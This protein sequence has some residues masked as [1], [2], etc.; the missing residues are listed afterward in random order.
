LF[1]YQNGVWDNASPQEASQ[2]IAV[3]LDPS[4]PGTVI[5]ALGGSAFNQPIFLSRDW[6]ET[7]R[8][9]TTKNGRISLRSL[10]PWLN[11]RHF[12][13]A[14]ADL[15]VDPHRPGRLWLADWMGVWIANNYAAKRMTWRS[16]ET[17]REEMVAMS[18]MTPPIGAPLF[19]G[20]VDTN[21]FRHS[22]VDQY[23]LRQLSDVGIW[24]SFG[25]D[26]HERNPALM[27][28]V[29]TRGPHDETAGGTGGFSTD[30][31]RTWKAFS[32][33]GPPPMK[34]AY[35]AE[36]PKRLVA[37]GLGGTPQWSAD[38]GQTWRK[39]EGVEATPIE[40]YWHWDHPLAADRVD[41]EAFYLHAADQFWV[42]R[43][44]GKSFDPKGF[45]QSGG[46][47][48]VEA[49][50]GAPGTAWV[51][52][53]HRGLH[54]TRDY[55]ETFATVRQI[56]RSLLFSLGVPEPGSAEPTLFVYG[57]LQ[58]QSRL[59]LYRS[60]DGGR[61]WID[62]GDPAQPVGNEPTV[63]RGDRQV[64][65]RVFVGTNGRGVFVGTPR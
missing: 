31:G 26:F 8:E 47:V 60:T 49:E 51:S 1:R 43:N 61:N 39:A 56:D 58:G 13:G 28:R 11:S 21:G 18:L 27:V 9:Y 52:L 20:T 29:G 23:P 45:M 3:T 34:I 50:P 53:D 36:D 37:L 64:F 54:V 33:E 55:G 7:W 22:R 42:S 24:N 15:A 41:G 2:I 10:V 19:T 63:M 12:G 44:G 25:F 59:G 46:R 30:N 38:L 65:G 5:A 48:F 14:I 32:W 6:G 62:I 16:F 17:G 57:Q 4:E 40:T 35:S